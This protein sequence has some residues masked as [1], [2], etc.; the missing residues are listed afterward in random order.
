[1]N[2]RIGLNIANK[3]SGEDFHP[4][5]RDDFKGEKAQEPKELISATYIKEQG[6]TWVTYRIWGV[7]KTI[8]I[9]WDVVNQVS[10]YFTPIKAAET[11]LKEF[12]LP[13]LVRIIIGYLEI[14]CFEVCVGCSQQY[15]CSCGTEPLFEIKGRWPYS[16]DFRKHLLDDNA[17]N[18]LFQAKRCLGVIEMSEKR[19]YR[20]NS[21]WKETQQ[22]RF[23]KAL[24]HI[25]AL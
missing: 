19:W 23:E 9:C 20:E 3:M 11:L 6:Y 17:Y 8:K 2:L 5:V 13:S 22:K 24:K 10:N 16:V 7:E 18:E 15:G 21:E 12:T 14:E 1:V 25:E 4:F